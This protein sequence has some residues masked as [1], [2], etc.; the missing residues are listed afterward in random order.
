MTFSTTYPI[1]R[2]KS[3]SDQY[4]VTGIPSGQ[5]S[6]WPLPISLT[7]GFGESH[8]D[9]PTW[10]L[11]HANAIEK[12]TTQSFKA[13]PGYSCRIPDRSAEPA[14]LENG[15]TSLAV[16][17]RAAV[18]A[19]IAQTTILYDVPERPEVVG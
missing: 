18:G 4:V 10:R 1:A 2:R 7:I 14:R 9:S 12:R 8:A 11:R 13:V 15:A 6:G 16:L 17:L 19:H 5:L 3:D